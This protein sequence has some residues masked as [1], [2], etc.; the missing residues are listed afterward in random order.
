MP[1]TVKHILRN[2][3]VCLSPLKGDKLRK[4]LLY[5]NVLRYARVYTV[6]VLLNF[7][8]QLKTHPA[9]RGKFESK[10]TLDT[11]P[12]MLVYLKA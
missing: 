8:S 11:Q 10:Y 1:F 6:I 7:C 4:V 9:A 5:A 2:T 12:V 3:H